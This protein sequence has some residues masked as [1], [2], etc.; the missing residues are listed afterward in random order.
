[1]PLTPGL[2]PDIPEEVYHSQTGEWADLPSKSRL[3]KLLWSPAHCRESW[4]HP[5]PPTD[6]MK[7][8]SAVHSLVLTPKIFEAEY[9]IAGPCCAVT[10]KGTGC[11]ND[12]KYLHGGQWYCGTHKPDGEPDDKKSLSAE[13]FA[14][15]TAMRDSI[16]AHPAAASLIN[17]LDAVE[18]SAIFLDPD[19]DLLCKMR[20]DGVS[21]AN[22][23][24]IDIKTT[25]DARKGEFDR[26]IFDFGYHRQ[27]A[28]YLHGAASIGQKFN[29]FVIIAV[30]KTAPYAV[31]VYRLKDDIVEL[32]WLDVGQMMMTYRTCAEQN[33]WPAYSEKVE[34]IG[35]PGWAIRKVTLAREG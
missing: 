20:M 26:S 15:A 21:H 35:I 23:C 17:S 30:E 31:G 6:E 18:L 27:A 9:V 29:H 10:K 4:L 14:K 16:M 12:G 2:Y 33:Y 5:K 34:D 28:M 3:E 19:A 24:I 22:E 8:G 7:F 25:G 13:D 32:G 11:K 1:M